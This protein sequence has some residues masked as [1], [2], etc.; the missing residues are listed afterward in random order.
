MMHD[1]IE[2]VE[3]KRRESMDEKDDGPMDDDDE[4]VLLGMDHYKKLIPIVNG[5]YAKG[6]RKDR[7][8]LFAGAIL[9]YTANGKIDKVIIRHTRI[10]DVYK[11]VVGSINDSLRTGRREPGMEELIALMTDGLNKLPD[12]VPK[13]GE[14][15]TRMMNW[16]EGID[17]HYKVGNVLKMAE[18]GSVGK[19]KPRSATELYKRRYRIE[20]FGGLKDISNLNAAQEEVLYAPG[21]HYR[22]VS[23]T[24]GKSK[25]KKGQP[26]SPQSHRH[27]ALQFI[28][29]DQQELRTMDQNMIVDLQAPVVVG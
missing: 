23:V 24:D 14:I 9:Q 29:A 18:V 25:A 28:A 17:I 3:I 22:V 12:Y 5:V 26:G 7:A 2:Q 1:D 20:F 6:M 15:P 27:I 8:W 16:Y 21:S 19:K 13:K 4:R 10:K 11:G